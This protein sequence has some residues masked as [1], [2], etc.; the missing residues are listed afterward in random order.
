L[1]VCT[2]QEEHGGK[3]R[4]IR[5]RYRLR[6]R[7]IAL[8]MAAAGFVLSAIALRLH[9]A[10]AASALLLWATGLVVAWRRGVAA[11]TRITSIVDGV[12]KELGLISC[13]P[14]ADTTATNCTEEAC[15][16]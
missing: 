16:A 10:I 9:P 12:A 15:H 5:V 14:K 1:R 8:F 11:A 13:G 3:K 6:P 4:L 2:T 7:N